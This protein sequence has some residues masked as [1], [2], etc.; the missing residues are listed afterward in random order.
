M[1]YGHVWRNRNIGVDTIPID[2]SRSLAVLVP[3]AGDMGWPQF[4]AEKCL[5]DV[6]SVIERLTKYSM[7]QRSLPARDSGKCRSVRHAL[8]AAKCLGEGSAINT[9]ATAQENISWFK[10]KND[11]LRELYQINKK[12]QTN[13]L[14]KMR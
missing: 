6:E 13:I 9:S 1:K 12:T 4:G 2:I 14:N 11:A 3:T 10:L 7:T 8:N 5:I